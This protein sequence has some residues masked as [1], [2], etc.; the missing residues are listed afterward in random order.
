MVLADYHTP[1]RDLEN[2]KLTR[3]S[4][5]LSERTTYLTRPLHRRTELRFD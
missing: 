4:S 1:W 2:S 3:E 5:V